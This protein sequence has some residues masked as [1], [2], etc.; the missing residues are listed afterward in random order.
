MRFSGAPERASRIRIVDS[1]RVLHR[2]HG[3]FDADALTGVMVHARGVVAALVGAGDVVADDA[4]ADI[5]DVAA[6]RLGCRGDAA[7]W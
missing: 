3:R 4:I 6:A 5:V 2:L 1:T 7:A